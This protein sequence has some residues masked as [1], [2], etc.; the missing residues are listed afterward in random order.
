ML[1]AITALAGVGFPAFPTVA[2][3]VLAPTDPTVPMNRTAGMPADR[4]PWL[5]ANHACVGQG[6]P[7][8]AFSL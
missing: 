2:Q 6:R 5:H 7:G 1:V 3:G 4:T 8:C